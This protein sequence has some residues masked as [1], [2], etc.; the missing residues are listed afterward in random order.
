MSDSDILRA[1][2]AS[3]HSSP[4]PS[5]ESSAPGVVNNQGFIWEQVAD[6]LRKHGVVPN[7]PGPQS[8]PS[9]STPLP[10]VDSM[11][12]E[13]LQSSPDDQSADPPSEKSSGDAPPDHLP[14]DTPLPAGKPPPT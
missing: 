5:Y 9:P 11:C 6:R 10:D 2:G 12:P 13:L 7:P 8:T 3:P 14:S 4:Q 1:A